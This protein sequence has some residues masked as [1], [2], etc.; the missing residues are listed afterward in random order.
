VVATLQKLEHTYETVEPVP[1]EIQNT[2]IN[3]C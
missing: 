2:F 1:K 3:P